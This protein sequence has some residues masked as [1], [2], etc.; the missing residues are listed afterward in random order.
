MALKPAFVSTLVQT[1]QT[2]FTGGSN[3][4]PQADAGHAPPLHGMK[5]TDNDKHQWRQQRM[6]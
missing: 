4:D 2:G 6:V 5:G 3:N 1:G